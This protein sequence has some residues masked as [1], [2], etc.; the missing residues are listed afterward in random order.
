MASGTCV[1]SRVMIR[2]RVTAKR[3]AAVLTRAQMHPRGADLHAFR[4]LANLRLFD[5]LDGIEM[6]AAAAIHSDLWFPSF[7]VANR[8]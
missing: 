8:I 3:N 1:F 7:V 6:G 5:R 2:R 4:A